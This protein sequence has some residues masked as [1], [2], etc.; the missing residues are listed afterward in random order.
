[1]VIKLFVDFDFGE[2]YYEAV[3]EASAHIKWLPQ[4]QVQIGNAT[5]NQ[6]SNLVIS[7]SHKEKTWMFN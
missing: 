6:D 2:G 1:M 7:V 5:P 4:D 3:V